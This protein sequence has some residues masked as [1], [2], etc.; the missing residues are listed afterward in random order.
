M[1]TGNLKAVAWE[2]AEAATVHDTLE[3]ALRGDDSGQDAAGDAP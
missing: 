3:A 1:K 2:G